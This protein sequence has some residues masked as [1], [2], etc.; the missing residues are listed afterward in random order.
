[1]SECRFITECANANKS[2]YKCFDYNMY[3]SKKE[4]VPLRAR[5]L[6]NKQK[7]SGIDFE[8]RGTKQ[9]NSAIKQSK[10]AARRQIASGALHFALGDMIT[11][12]DLTASLAEFKERGSKDAKG[13]KQ[14]TIKKEWLD[15]IKEE[16]HNMGKDYYYLPFSFKGSDTDYVAM[17][18][19]M[20]LSYVQTIQ[21]LV[22]QNKILQ[23]RG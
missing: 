7:K 20:L 23:E 10:D 8:N 5:S 4:R 13:S 2:C 19:E 11:E 3:S 6:T 12:E 18:Y 1:M 15:G 22:E 14:I 16:A 17:E 9:Y 21:M